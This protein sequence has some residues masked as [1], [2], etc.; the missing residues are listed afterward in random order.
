MT[1]A[2]NREIAA[3]VPMIRLGLS[4]FRSIILTDR[5]ARCGGFLCCPM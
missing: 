1:H 3:A 2:T 5:I 4:V